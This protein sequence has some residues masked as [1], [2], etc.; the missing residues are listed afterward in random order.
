LVLLIILS[1]RNYLEP[2]AEAKPGR[3]TRVGMRTLYFFTA[4][5]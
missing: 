3:N 4:L 5:P 2:I 1:G